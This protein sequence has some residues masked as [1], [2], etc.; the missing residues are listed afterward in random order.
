MVIQSPSSTAV[1]QFH[2]GGNAWRDPSGFMNHP[3]HAKQHKGPAG[4]WVEIQHVPIALLWCVWLYFY[5]FKFYWDSNPPVHCQEINVELNESLFLQTYS[6]NFQ[7]WHP[8]IVP[9]ASL[10]AESTEHLKDRKR[11]ED[12]T[13]KGKPQKGCELV[14]TC[15]RREKKKGKMNQIACQMHF[16]FRLEIVTYS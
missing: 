9:A 3:E 11:L 13:V 4:G 7:Q 14:S 10:E 15:F 8:I 16:G 6:S 1:P 2:T 12:H 5:L